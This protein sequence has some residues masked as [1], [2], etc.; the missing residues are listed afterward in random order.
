MSFTLENTVLCYIASL[1]TE[2]THSYSE[3]RKINYTE[4]SLK[5]CLFNHIKLV[6]SLPI[7]SQGV[8]YSPLVSIFL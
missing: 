4:M 7:I 2:I 5:L 3:V 1:F 6:G 8:I